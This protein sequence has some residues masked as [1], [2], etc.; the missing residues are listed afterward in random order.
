[1]RLV[2]ITMTEELAQKIDNLLKMATTPNNQVCAPV[3]NDDELNEYIAIGEILEPMGYA[4]RLGGNLFHITPAGMYFVKTGGFTTMY[5]EKRN[6]E[7]KKGRGR[8]EKGCKNKTMV[9][10][11][12]KCSYTN[13]LHSGSFG[14]VINSLLYVAPPAMPGLPLCL[15]KQVS[16]CAPARIQCKLFHAEQIHIKPLCADS[17]VLFER[18]YHPC[19]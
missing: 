17:L 1:M 14:M 3:S 7:E 18:F 8:Q 2:N 11:L 15:L 16:R 10:H 6:E 13:Q 9:S 19:F 4:K 12:G 5:R